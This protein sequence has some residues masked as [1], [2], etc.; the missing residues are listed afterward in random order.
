MIKFIENKKRQK[1]ISINLFM[2]AFVYRLI[3][4]LLVFCF[5]G[6]FGSDFNQN[7]KDPD[8]RRYEVGA[9]YYLESA[10]SILD[11]KAIKS[12]YMRL[13]DSTGYYFE[14][15]K[16]F[17]TKGPLWY[18][19]ICVLIYIFKTK[20][21]I[22]IFNI[23][24]SSLAVVLLY[25]LGT[26]ID[27]EKMGKRAADLLC[28]LPYPAMFSCFAYKDPLVMFC[29]LY[30]MYKSSQWKKLNYI[31]RD[32]KTDVLKIVFIGVILTMLRSGFGAVI[33]LCLFINAVN[34]E[35]M[36]GNHGILSGK[37]SRKFFK[38]CIPIIVITLVFF[39]N[40]METIVY[41]FG[42]YTAGREANLAGA[43]ISLLTIDSITDIYKLPF[44]YMFSVLMPINMFDGISSWYDIIANL[45][46]LMVPI[47]IGAVLFVVRR[48]KS[49][50]MFFWIGMLFYVVSIVTSLNIFRHYYSL[51]PVTLL[52]FSEFSLYKNRGEMM[53]LLFGTMCMMA[54][55]V[56][57]YSI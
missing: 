6:E 19:I 43:T 13:G 9:E 34:I 54:M 46:I 26:L 30:L 3:I 36:F 44:T 25:K 1:Q 7:A 33:C 38:I 16:L 24:I 55:L 41:K 40:Y 47:S 20:W 48:N 37:V 21:V 8:D 29:I 17:L 42:H 11:I 57:F 10:T 12:A 22:R 15:F 49:D 2:K 31:V 5:Q 23:F 14:D 45:N 56:I 51:M 4:L 27:S 52:A 50:K 28:F 35:D 39:A 53:I 18:G 32:H